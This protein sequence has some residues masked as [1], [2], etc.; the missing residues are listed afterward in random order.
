[1]QH[2]DLE[3]RVFTAMQPGSYVALDVNDLDT[4]RATLGAQYEVIAEI[5]RRRAF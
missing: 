3:R 4:L 5:A 2:L 1:V